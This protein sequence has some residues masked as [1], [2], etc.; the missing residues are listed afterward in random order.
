VSLTWTP[1][2]PSLS[3]FNIYRG[4]QSGGPYTRINSALR[5]DVLLRRNRSKFRRRRELLLQRSHRNSSLVPLAFALS[6][7]VYLRRHPFTSFPERVPRR[8]VRATTRTNNGIC[9]HGVRAS[10][11]SDVRRIPL[12]PTLRCAVKRI[13]DVRGTN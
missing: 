10:A 9:F 12:F 11:S 7:S 4:A 13:A 2:S 5:L 8:A 6:G 3:G 1:G